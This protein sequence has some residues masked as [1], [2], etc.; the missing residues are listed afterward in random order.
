MRLTDCI[1]LGACISLVFAMG[2]C[3]ISKETN[4]NWEALETEMTKFGIEAQFATRAVL[5]L[6]GNY[7]V[8]RSE[9]G[10]YNLTEI[11]QSTET[12]LSKK[13]PLKLNTIYKAC[14]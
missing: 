2:A 4:L 7:Q 14:T 5:L 11:V 3:E 9:S 12:K 1:M 10:M 13:I 6:Y 8:Y